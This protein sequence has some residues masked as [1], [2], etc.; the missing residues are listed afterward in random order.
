MLR[1][2]GDA[3]RTLY[4][5]KDSGITLERI[6]DYNQNIPSERSSFWATTRSQGKFA[7][8]LTT[9]MPKQICDQLCSWLPSQ[10]REFDN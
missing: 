3:L 5:C 9:I 6:W 10:S 2:I 7:P 8:K 4:Q 1:L